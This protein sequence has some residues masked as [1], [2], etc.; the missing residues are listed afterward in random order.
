[1]PPGDIKI[2]FCKDVGTAQRDSAQNGVDH[3]WPTRVDFDDLNLI[4]EKGEKTQLLQALKTREKR[5]CRR[6]VFLGHRGSDDADPTSNQRV[7]L[8]RGHEGRAP[9]VDALP[10]VSVRQPDLLC[11]NAIQ[12]SVVV[13]FRRSS[14]VAKN[15]IGT[16]RRKRRPEVWNAAKTD[17]F[18]RPAN[19]TTV[20]PRQR[21][22]FP[23]P[24]RRS[25]WLLCHSGIQHHSQRDRDPAVSCRP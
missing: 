9:Q 25:Y 13:L 24:A 5:A 19:A 1:M 2:Q 6:R 17:F 8:G 10:P 12:S 3:Q 7:V 4:I 14:M 22:Q 23:L 18:K 16:Q 15:K 21:K 11:R 20:T